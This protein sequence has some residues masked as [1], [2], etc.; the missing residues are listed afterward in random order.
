MVALPNIGGAL[1][2]TPQRLADAHYQMPCSNA[3]NRRNQFKFAGVPQTGQPISAASRPKFTILGDMWRTYC[4][5]LLNKFFF[6]LSIRALVAK[7]QPDKAGLWSQSR[8]LGL[9]TVSIR[10]GNVVDG[11]WVTGQMGHENRMGHMGHGSLQVLT[12]DPSVFNS[13]A[14]LIYCGNDNISCQSVMHVQCD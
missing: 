5:Q 11:S 7:I 14:G 8:R 6:R 12:H 1:C 13:M 3:A 2:S 4:C 9:E 10:A